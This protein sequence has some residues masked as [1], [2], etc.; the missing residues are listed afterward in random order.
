MDDSGTRVLV[1]G[2][3]FFS[4]P[5]LSADGRLAYLAWDHPNMPWDGTT[6]YVATARPVAGGP[7][8]SVFQPEWSPDGR[9]LVF[10]S[11]RSGWWNLYRWDAASGATQPL[12]PMDAE[13]GLPQWVFGMYTYAFAGPGRLVCSYVQNGLGRLAVVDLA[14][15]AL[16]PIDTPYTEFSYVRAEGD[17]VVFRGASPTLPGSIVALDLATGRADVLQRSTA[18]AGDPVVSRC[19]TAS[20][21]S[22]TRA[23]AASPMR[24]TT[25]R[26]IPI[27]RR[28]TGS[29][30]RCW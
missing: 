28:P 29:V 22:T 8:E 17:R 14:S 4:S 2:H 15:G 23:R 26:S 25:P 10:V 16:T 30:R 27:T 3:D 20:S 24:C 11:D 18:V 19:F 21:P 7:D 5:K 1:S 9:S 13:F 12:A 6:L